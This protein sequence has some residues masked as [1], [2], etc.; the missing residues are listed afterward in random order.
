M[1]SAAISA[2]TQLDTNVLQTLVDYFII[3]HPNYAKNEQFESS[4][5]ADIYTDCPGSI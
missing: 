2:G 3:A 5:F 1:T 4:M